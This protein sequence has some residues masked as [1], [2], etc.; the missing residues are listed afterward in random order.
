MTTIQI[1]DIGSDINGFNSI[2]SVFQ[3]SKELFFEDMELDFS[4][5]NFFE[6]N[7]SSPLFSVVAHL[8][9]NLNEVR[10][11]NLKPKVEQVLMKNEFLTL[12]NIKAISDSNKTT[13]PFRLFKAN[14]AE[15]F[16]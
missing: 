7:M 3:K 4:K 9:N 1:G 6:A 12:F 8:R 14:S 11:S 13:I 5:C 16:Y 10:I 2:A 15:R